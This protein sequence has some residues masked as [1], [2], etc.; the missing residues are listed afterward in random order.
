MRKIFLLGIVFFMFMVSSVVVQAALPG[1]VDVTIASSFDEENKNI[2]HG[3]PQSKALGSFLALDAS[4][5]QSGHN[6]AFWVVN[7]VI[8]TDLNATSSIRVQTS[9][10]IHAVFY[11]NGEHAVLFVDSNGKLIDVSYVLNGQSVTAP[12]YA[13]YTKPEMSVNT[14]TPWATREGVTSLENITSSRVYVLQYTINASPVTIS[15]IGGTASSIEVNQNDVVTVIASNPGS[16]THWVDGDGKVLSYK[17]TFIFTAVSNMTVEA[18]SDVVTP[19]SMVTITD[20]SGI[21]SDKESYVGRF[22]LQGT[23]EVVEFGFL[24]SET[25]TGEITFDTAGV[26]VAK[27]NTYN[28]KTNEFLMSFNY[29][30]YL[31]IRAYMVVDNGT[32][33][34]TVYSAVEGSFAS[35]LFISEYIEGSSNNKAIEIF[36]GTGSTVDLTPYKVGLYSNGSETYGNNIELTGTIANGETIVIYNSGA[37]T[38]FKI[39]ELDSNITYF[40]G[41]DAVAL[42]KNEVVIDV[43]GVIGTDPGSSWSVGTGST[44]DNTLVRKTSVSSPT[45][46]WDANEWDVYPKDTSS[47]L[48]SHSFGAISYSDSQSIILD[49]NDLSLVSEVKEATTLDLPTSGPNGTTIAWS[50]DKPLTITDGGV[51]TPPEG[52]PVTVVMT[53][54]V[55][56]GSLSKNVTFEVTVGKTDAEKL[57]EDKDALDIATTITEAGDMGLP[58]VV[59]VYS[60]TIAWSSDTPL[61]ITNSG[62]VT[63]PTSGS[64]KVTMT[65]TI[66]QNGTTDTKVFVIT[67]FAETEQEVITVTASYEGST[68]NMTANNNATLIGL[69]PSLFTVT[70]VERVGNA[71]HVGLN[72]A[73]EIRL[74]NGTDSEGNILEIDVA[75]GYAISEVVITFG[76]SVTTALIQA[77][78]TELHNE[79]LTSNG[80]LTFDSLTASGISIKNTG[81]KQIYILSIAISYVAN[82]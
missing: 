11:K 78:T 52:Q 10:D 12:G 26:I 8:R 60:S 71:L 41:D 17:S 69:D 61:T 51:V 1:N 36:N 44:A 23:D 68:T 38:A 47:Y 45:N 22:E 54:T 31:S 18:K 28:Q 48:G 65:A 73:G 75:A 49:A 14:T 70:S 59:S 19:E 80:V 55:S 39:G 29:V 46:T 81:T 35:D 76:S 43:I 74:Y 79:A 21:R 20:V 63:L 30:T 58:S 32:T 4:T 5:I 27:S 67:V 3:A 34:E 24:L 37:D 53:A 33:I 82:P 77:D 50:S 15:V 2:A 40:N 42:L 62:I 7:G 25:Q 56:K 13:G 16:F 72:K 66:D 9:L 6:F 57:A 64:V